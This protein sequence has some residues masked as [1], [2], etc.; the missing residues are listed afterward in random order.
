MTPHARA[1][2]LKGLVSREGKV[3]DL[4]PPKVCR[5]DEHARVVVGSDSDGSAR[6]SGGEEY[7]W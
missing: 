6:D 7:G 2:E 5:T 1:L 4:K 3:W